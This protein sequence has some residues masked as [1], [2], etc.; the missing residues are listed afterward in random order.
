MDACLISDAGIRLLDYR[1]D[2]LPRLVIPIRRP[3]GTKITADAQ[4]TESQVKLRWYQLVAGSVGL[5][6]YEEIR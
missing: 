6:I 2:I 3:L 1:G 4:P 5:L